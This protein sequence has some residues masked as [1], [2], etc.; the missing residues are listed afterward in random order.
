MTTFIRRPFPARPSSQRAPGRGQ[1]RRRRLQAVSRL[2]PWFRARRGLIP[3]GSAPG[4]DC[5]L[6]GRLICCQP[7]PG[8]PPAS[9]RTAGKRPGGKHRGPRRRPTTWRPRRAP[10]ALLDV[11]PREPPPMSRRRCPPSQAER[12]CRGLSPWGTTSEVG[13]GP[14][15]AGHRRHRWGVA[16]AA[17]AILG[18]SVLLPHGALFYPPIVKLITSIPP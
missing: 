9:A 12:T 3:H 7:R 4:E 8:T 17:F 14:R 2:S 6:G 18:A 13:I 11:V 1:A 16:E 10:C 5:P 15:A